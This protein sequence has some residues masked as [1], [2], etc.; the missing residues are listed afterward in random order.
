MAVL[1]VGGN[2]VVLAVAWVVVLSQLNLR[3][4][5]AEAVAVADVAVSAGEVVV[6]SVEEVAVGV[7]ASA[8]GLVAVAAVSGRCHR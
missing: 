2:R 4:L 6:A 7:V 3:L 5:E 8:A 1:S